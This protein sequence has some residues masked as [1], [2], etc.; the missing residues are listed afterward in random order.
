MHVKQEKWPK[1]V[2]RTGY[3]D[4][5]RQVRVGRLFENTARWR[6]GPCGRSERCKRL[7]VGDTVIAKEDVVL[8]QKILIALVPIATCSW[9]KGLQQNGS[10]R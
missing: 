7:E 6:V 9:R 1:V 8:P 10:P 4:C 2:F 3:G 5:E